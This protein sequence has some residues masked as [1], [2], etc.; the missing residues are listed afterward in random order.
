MRLAEQA[1]LADGLAYQKTELQMR[2]DTAEA[3][4]AD[5]EQKLVGVESQEAQ[6]AAE[7]L[8]LQDQLVD[9]QVEQGSTRVMLAEQSEIANGLAEQKAREAALLGA[10]DIRPQDRK[11]FIDNLKADLEA[12]REANVTLKHELDSIKATDSNPHAQP[13]TGAAPSMGAVQ[14]SG[15]DGAVVEEA[16]EAEASKK[17]AAALYGVKTSG[18]SLR[19][20]RKQNRQMKSQYDKNRRTLQT[21]EK[22]A[23]HVANRHPTPKGGDCGQDKTQSTGSGASKPRAPPTSKVAVLPAPPFSANVS[24]SLLV[25]HLD[26]T[27]L[28]SMHSLTLA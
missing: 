24:M 14:E 2:L 15:A 3:E 8:R 7:V 21:I 23:P 26:T 25:N 16:A 12:L 20:L 27:S 19:Q 11:S 4:G 1:D 17:G 22:N 9:L 10:A 18:M 6:K 5:L 28:H 13:H